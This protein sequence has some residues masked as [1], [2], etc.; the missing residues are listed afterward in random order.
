VIKLKVLGFILKI[1]KAFE[2]LVDFLG[3]RL[4]FNKLHP[5]VIRFAL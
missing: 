1:Y 4:Q 5:P 2:S 3:S